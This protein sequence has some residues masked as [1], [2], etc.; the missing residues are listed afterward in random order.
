MYTKKLN[1]DTIDGV[2]A[3]HKC[4]HMR[5][6][7]RGFIGRARIWYVNYAWDYDIIY[8]QNS[9]SGNFITTVYNSRTGLNKADVDAALE[10][11]VMP[12]YEA[13]RKKD[14]AS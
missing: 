14:V 9:D 3:F 12:A 7:K 1:F 5:M 8:K 6:S 11:C 13:A 10:T 4:L 2:K